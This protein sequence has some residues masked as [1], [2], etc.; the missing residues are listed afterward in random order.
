MRYVRDILLGILAVSLATSSAV[1]AQAFSTTEGAAKAFAEETR[2]EKSAPPKD[3]ALT[4]S[5]RQ[6]FMDKCTSIAD[7]KLCSCS[8][9]KTETYLA[10]KAKPGAYL[11]KENLIPL[12]HYIPMAVS[13]CE[14]EKALEE[15]LD[16][17][18]LKEHRAASDIMKI[19]KKRNERLIKIYNRH[20]SK[21][22][23]AQGKITL[24]FTIDPEGKVI[25]ISIVSSTT[26][27][28]ELDKKVKADVAKWKFGKVIS[29]NTTVTIPF[30]FSE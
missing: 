6:I 1:A 7:T 4:E 13:E 24:K 5:K 2:E 15:G 27:D 23:G 3:S 21:K 18:E 16:E 25:S 8:L 17:I 14:D 22:P 29:G 10:N 28:E 26:G 19:V 11:I 12:E 20:L 9:K 30:T